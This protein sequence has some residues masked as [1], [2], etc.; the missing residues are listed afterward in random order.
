MTIAETKLAKAYACFENYTTNHNDKI[1]NRLYDLIFPLL[2]KHT[3]GR[4]D[5][6]VSEKEQKTFWLQSSTENFMFSLATWED[7]PQ[8]IVS[9]SEQKVTILL[10]NLIAINNLHINITENDNDKCNFVKYEINFSYLNKVD[11]HID[12]LVPKYLD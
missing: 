10:I 3:N 11:Y 1:F 6:T 5:V 4:L 8:L 2:Y 9:D 12:M 7:E